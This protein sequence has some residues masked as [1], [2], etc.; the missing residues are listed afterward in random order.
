MET[1]LS[2]AT[3]K[4][5]KDIRLRAVRICLFEELHVEREIHLP[6]RVSDPAMGHR[7]LGFDEKVENPVAPLGHLS[8]TQPDRDIVGVVLEVVGPDRCPAGV[9]PSPNW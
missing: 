9:Q 7:V 2:H 8:K 3:G 5:E 4:I 1:H 6:L